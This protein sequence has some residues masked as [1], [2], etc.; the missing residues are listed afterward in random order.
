MPSVGETRLEFPVLPLRFQSLY[1]L[2][3]L[4]QQGLDRYWSTVF[5]SGAMRAAVRGP[6][7]AQRLTNGGITDRRRTGF[8]VPSV[9]NPVVESTAFG[10]LGLDFDGS[11]RA[12]KRDLEKTKCAGATRLAQIA[13]VEDLE[14]S[15]EFASNHVLE[16]F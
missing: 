2:Y 7:S 15:S 12:A 1:R 8:H 13:A 9:R 4:S 5:A 6:K 11:V 3:D 16:V 14:A 10:R